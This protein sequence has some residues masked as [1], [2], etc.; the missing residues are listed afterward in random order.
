MFQ[1]WLVKMAKIAVS[2]A[3]SALFGA[4]EEHHGKGEIAQNRYG[5]Q[6]I[7]ERDQHQLGAAALRRQ[8]ALSEGEEERS[9][10]VSSI[11]RTVRGA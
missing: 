6:H 7:E 2:S 5:L 3:P 1:A 9:P 8:R 11:R 4:D 10:S